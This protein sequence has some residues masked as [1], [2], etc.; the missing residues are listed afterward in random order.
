MARLSR[1]MLSACQGS[2]SRG[3]R[4]TLARASG[5]APGEIGFSSNMGPIY[6]KLSRG[7]SRLRQS[8]SRP[9]GSGGGNPLIEPVREARIEVRL[10]GQ[11]ARPDIPGAV[12]L[13]GV[14]QV[15]DGALTGGIGWGQASGLQG[16]Q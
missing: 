6:R 11:G 5:M 7:G 1:Q 10:D 9:T 3:E 16:E 8:Q 12:L 13:L 14:Q 15:A 4:S 2:L